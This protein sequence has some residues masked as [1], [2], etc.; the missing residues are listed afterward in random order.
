MVIGGLA[1]AALV[2]PPAAMGATTVSLSGGTLTIVGSD[3]DESI[4]IGSAGSN[5][6]GPTTDVRGG[7]ADMVAGTGCQGFGQPN[8]PA[9]DDSVF[10]P[11]NDIQRIS[12]TLG[13]GDDGFSAG[14]ALPMTVDAGPGDD[15]VTTGDGPDVVLGG[16]DDDEIDIDANTAAGTTSEVDGG[17][18]DDELRIGRDGRATIVR[19]GQGR[20][21][22]TYRFGSSGKAVSLDNVAN[23]GGAGE[24]D[25]VRSDVEDLIGTN[26]NDTLIG[27]GVANTLDGAGGTD[28]LEGLGGPDTLIGGPGTSDAT[29]GGEGADAIK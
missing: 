12:A 22:A 18:G 13:G 19:G 26:A 5:A 16:D 24:G 23:D 6:L 20:D 7:G 27:S 1:A 11:T 10:C 15:E 25:D 29:F 4:S 2:V 9:N 14:N 21:V 8:G 28:R 17:G 3:A